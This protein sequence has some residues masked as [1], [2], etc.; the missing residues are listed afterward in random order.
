MGMK[1]CK[2]ITFLRRFGAKVSKGC[3]KLYNQGLF[4]ESGIS[5]VSNEL[6]RANSFGRLK[7]FC[8]SRMTQTVNRPFGLFALCVLGTGPAAKDPHY[9][10][11][12]MWVPVRR[13][14]G[15]GFASVITISGRTLSKKG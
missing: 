13:F 9:G 1:Y 4:P 5:R 8:P 14:P 7:I 10:E 3:K 6:T 15:T 2:R 12:D 11:A